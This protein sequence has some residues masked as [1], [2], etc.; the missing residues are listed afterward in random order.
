M[1]DLSRKVR[2]IAAAQEGVLARRQLL[3]RGMT[4]AAVDHARLSD[5]LFDLHRGVY[6]IVP[7]ELLSEDGELIAA[8]LAVGPCGVISHGTAA[9]RWNLLAAPPVAI[10]LTTP[11][12]H[13]CPRASG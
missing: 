3:A 2:A 8:V 12:V 9:W 1:A 13:V 4:A 10:E 11:H 6:S 7:P 5:R